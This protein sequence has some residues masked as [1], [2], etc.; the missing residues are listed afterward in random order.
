MI[1]CIFLFSVKTVESVSL[2]GVIIIIHIIIIT[3]QDCASIHTV[4]VIIMLLQMSE[5]A[6]V[7]AI[8]QTMSELLFH[9]DSNIVRDSPPL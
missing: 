6:E 5:A 1:A 9:V 3:T 8:E 7:N 2:L 4:S